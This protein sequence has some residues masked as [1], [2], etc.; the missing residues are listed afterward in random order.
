MPEPIIVTGL[1]NR[2]FFE[3]H[4][5]AGR[6]GLVGGSEPANRLIARAQRHL[7]AD[8]AWSHWSHAF[9]FQG[10][11]ADGHHW[12]IESDLDIQRKIIRLGVQENR[13]AKYTDNG[14]Y[15]VVG[16]IDLGLTPVQEQQA[17]AHALE[18]VSAGT[19]YSLREIVGTVWAL[20]HPKWQPKENLLGQEKAFYCSA[21][22]R[23]VLDRAGVNLAPL[24]S[25]KNTTPEHLWRLTL[26]HTKWLMARERKPSALRRTVRRL[27]ERAHHPPRPD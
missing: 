9:L 13:V 25:E 26:P 17:L 6:I 20:R 15:P 2:E 14:A 3:T 7:D 5:Q 1:T 12:I 18:L 16:V 10:R 23:H 22:V 8:G 4:A 24:V 11:R 21:F 27:R 19:R